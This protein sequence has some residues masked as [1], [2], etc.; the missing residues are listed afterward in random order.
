[1]PRRGL[2]IVSGS[3]W[4][5][6]ALGSSQ[7]VSGTPHDSTPTASF[8]ARLVDLLPRVA[9]PAKPSLSAV[10]LVELAGPAK[11]SGTAYLGL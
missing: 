2:G 5:A 4:L 7:C 9:P 10:Q 11:I 1:M 6:T 8:D 3:L